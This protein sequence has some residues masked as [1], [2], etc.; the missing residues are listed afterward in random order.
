VTLHSHLQVQWAAFI[1][2][3]VWS[4]K[5]GPAPLGVGALCEARCGKSDCASDPTP[6]PTRHRAV[7]SHG[8]PLQGWGRH[9]LG[10]PQT[11]WE[12]GSNSWASQTLLGTAEELR[13]EWG[14]LGRLWPWG[15]KGKGQGGESSGRLSWG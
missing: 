8:T 4:K 14:P 5:W 12:S 10:S 15:P 11:C 9:S 2:T 13:T 1:A 3:L 7:R 6:T